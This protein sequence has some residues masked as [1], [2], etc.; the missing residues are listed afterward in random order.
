[1][2]WREIRSVVTWSIQMR[3]PVADMLVYVDRGGTLAEL[4]AVDGDGI[5]SP[6]I[7]RVDIREA[8]VLNDD[9]L[10]VANNADTLA[11]DDTLGTLAD[12]TLVGS[13]GH[14]KHTS[15][16][17]CDALDDGGIGLVVGAPVVLVDGNLAGGS[18]APGSA[19]GGS[20]CTFSASEVKSLGKDDDTSGGV[21]EVVDELGGGG[22]VDRGC[23]ATASYA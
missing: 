2:C 4:T 23:A 3:S 16:V 21:L 19:S 15:L 22:W 18:S 9:V 8:N 13:N 17:V 6:D 1:M 14:T 20:D 10:C 5:T 7:L 11:L 12:Q